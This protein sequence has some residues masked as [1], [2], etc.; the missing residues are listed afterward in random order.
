[1]NEVQA[2]LALASFF[3][4]S[5]GNPD[6]INQNHLTCEAASTPEEQETIVG[7]DAE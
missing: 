6:E 3:I 7:D 2:V 4:S 5:F 1:M